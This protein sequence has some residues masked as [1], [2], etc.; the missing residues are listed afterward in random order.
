MRRL[1]PRSL[2][3]SSLIAVAMIAVAVAAG[4][5][6]SEGSAESP[7]RGDW[8]ADA[9]TVSVDLEAVPIGDAVEAIAAQAGWPL[10]LTLGA[11][12]LALDEAG[13]SRVTMKLP[14]VPATSALEAVLTGSGLEARWVG[15]VLVVRPGRSGLATVGRIALQEGDEGVELE[16]QVG[17]DEEEVE[18]VELDDRVILGGPVVVDADEEVY[19]AVAIGGPL[20]V[21]GTVRGDAVALGGPVSIESGAVVEG[22]IVAVGGPVH[23]AEGA[24]VAGDI[25][26]VGGSVDVDPDATVEGQQVGVG[27]S[28]GGLI[29]GLVQSLTDASEAPASVFHALAHVV[30]AVALIVVT[31]LVLAFLPERVERVRGFLTARPGASVLGGLAIAVGLVPVIALL[32]ISIVGIPLVP[33]FLMAVAALLAMGITAAATWLGDRLPVL[34]GRKSPFVA[35]LLGVVVLVLVALVPIVGSLAVAALTF[36]AGG[37]ALFSRFGEPERTAPPSPA[38]GPDPTAA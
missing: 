34:K 29:S 12:S 25:T 21:R 32:C 26:A 14:G 38:A 24:R 19:D 13:A 6:W 36:A 1:A 9:P 20:T 30:H 18:T 35:L 15:G 7:L 33:V 37:A 3:A 5:A 17:Y 2:A 28:L 10:S 11:L 4:S 16:V 31:L 8:P 23:V 22:E 27:G